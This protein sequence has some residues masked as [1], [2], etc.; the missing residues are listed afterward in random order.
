MERTDWGEENKTVY[1][2]YNRS[3]PGQIEQVFLL[4]LEPLLFSSSED[5][6]T[7]PLRDDHKDTTQNNLTGV[8]HHSSVACVC[9]CV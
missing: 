3:Q 1:S 8:S 4:L 6:I 9:A 2:C 7:V 5:G